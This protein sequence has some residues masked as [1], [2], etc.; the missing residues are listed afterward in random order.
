MKRLIAL[1]TSPIGRV[2]ADG[3]I[4]VLRPDRFERVLEATRCFVVETL[5]GTKRKRRR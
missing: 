2:D 3:A 1:G 5:N 4:S